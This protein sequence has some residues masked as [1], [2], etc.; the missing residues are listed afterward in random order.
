MFIP[1]CFT[2]I[3]N[4]KPYHRY[5]S[6]G[7]KEKHSFSLMRTHESICSKKP[8]L[9]PVLP[10][11][12][13]LWRGISDEILKHLKIEHPNCVTDTK[14]LE[15]N[16]NRNV[17][18]CTAFVEDGVCFLIRI[19]YNKAKGLTVSNQ[20]FKTLYPIKYKLAFAVSKDDYPVY[21]LIFI[22][23]FFFTKSINDYS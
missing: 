20:N 21:K 4:C 16:L 10:V 15:L 19:V 13:C 1:F 8:Y 5:E 6:N 9:C 11:G 14:V 3:L 18:S 22:S 12:W 17:E 7:C 23:I 2:L